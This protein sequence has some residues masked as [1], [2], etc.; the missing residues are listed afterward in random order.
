[1]LTTNTTLINAFKEPAREITGGVRIYEG[2]TISQTLLPTDTLVS[3]TIN[4]TA[5]AGKF[6]GFAVAQQLTIEVLGKLELAKGT[7]LWPYL[8]TKGATEASLPFFYVDSVTGDETRN[9]TVIVAYDLIGKADKYTIQNT[10]IS[11]PLN[12]S[13]VAARIVNEIGGTA[14]AD[15]TGVD[16]TIEAGNFNGSE[17]LRA[18][19]ASI[20]EATGTICYCSTTDKV[21]FKALSDEIS[22]TLTGS[23]YFKFATEEAI[24]L[25]Q[26]A[27]NTQLG[28]NVASG[29]EG[30]TQVFWDNPFLELRDDKQAIIDA[31][32]AR[33]LGLT[34]IPYS[35]DWR[36]N[37]FY[38]IGDC[39]SVET[40][41]GET[42]KIYYFNDSLIYNG[43]LKSTS[44]WEATESV[45]IDAPAP[46]KTTLKQTYAKVDKI[47]QKIDLVA[48][49]SNEVREE[50]ASIRL[51]TDGVFTEV[52]QAQNDIFDNIAAV[53][54][55][56]DALN[57]RVQ[58][59]VTSENV[60]IEIQKELA[61]GVNSV[62]TTTGFTFDETGLTI[63]KS[64][65]E[66]STTITEDGMTIYRDDTEVLVVNNIGVEATN[67][68]ARTY[69]IIG[70]NSR[71]EDYNET[72]TG[73]FWI[74]Q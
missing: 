22:D 51:E 16:I 10:V 65:T 1:M 39:I 68:H 24:T 44:S 17:T 18:V 14:V 56:M 70:T 7:Q 47:N 23:N 3:M 50:M 13:G 29:V 25:T 71:L 4:R 33:V 28:D 53:N 66:M 5:P 2:S 21:V 57:K 30:H 40:V 27:A 15:F 59:A 64:G 52:K 54:S 60:S 46:A 19:L 61:N 63:D 12:L 37:P 36:A 69:L 62:T 20:A 58:M 6:F 31:I 34:L 41:K 67:L 74:G 11:Y 49:E 8:G 9:K 73:M 43:G 38:E 35:L 42:K 26:V 48:A 55:D 45:D 72:R 32:G